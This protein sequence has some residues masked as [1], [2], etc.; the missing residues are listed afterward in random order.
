MRRLIQGG[1]I[2]ALFGCATE[3]VP[4]PAGTTSAAQQTACVGP[5]FR[6]LD[7]WL[8]SWDVSWS[9]SPG[10]PAGQGTNVIT[11]DFEGCVVH[12]HFDGGP[13][14]GNLIGESWSLYHAP[15]Q[16]WRQT[17]VDN[18]GGYFALVGGPQDNKFVLV[19]S[20]LSDNTPQQRMVFEE[21]TPNAFKWRW[22]RTTDQGATWADSWV[23]R[24]T[25]RAQP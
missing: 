2:L 19:S 6:Q 15:T 20:S 5:E 16:R 23:I 24:Y 9:A 17:W 18:Q 1:L 25:R 7:F 3:Q 4:A 8:G 13:T 22:Q 12:E 14:T 21:I 10:Q 11:R